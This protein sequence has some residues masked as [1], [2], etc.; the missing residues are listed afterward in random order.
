MVNNTD[1]KKEKRIVWNKDELSM[2]AAAAVDKFGLESWSS[3]MLPRV[4]AIQEILSI[5]RRRTFW[6]VNDIGTLAK[7][8][9][10]EVDM[11]RLAVQ[12]TETVTAPP[13][14]HEVIAAP[15]AP[16]PAPPAQDAPLAPLPIRHEGHNDESPVPMEIIEEIIQPT[17]SITD[18][19]IDK[20][21]DFLA[22]V[23]TETIKKFLTQS[24][25]ARILRNIQLGSMPEI[26][27]EQV[28]PREKPPTPKQEIA[29]EVAR[30]PV[31]LLCGFKPHQQSA[32]LNYQF[33]KPVRLKFWHDSGQGYGVLAAKATG[34]DAVFFTMEATSHNAVKIVVNL[35][36]PR[37]FRVTGAGSSMVAAIEKYLTEQKVT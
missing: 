35:K 16:Q 9:R 32:F 33:A 22:A 21:S 11:R 3:N 31:L 1:T 10:Q 14:P 8:I 5:E 25:I 20:A 15:P 4:R 23:L 2:L 13:V 30:L 29:Q 37:I 6:N 24:D 28:A 7:V 27:R 18:A 34:A 17:I 19:L 36:G 26:A 12:A